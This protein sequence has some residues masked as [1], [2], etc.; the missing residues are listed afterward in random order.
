MRLF[1]DTS[2]AVAGAPGIAAAR[3]PVLIEAAS[4]RARLDDIRCGASPSSTRVRLEGSPSLGTI[5]IADIDLERLDDF[6]RS[7]VLKPAQIV[8]TK[9]LTV[10][11]SARVDLGG[12]EWQSV[13]FT[14]NEIADGTVTTV[15]TRDLARATV[16]SLISNIDLKADALGLGLGLNA[17]ALTAPVQPAL[18][19]AAAPADDV[20]NA[21]SDV[22][23]LHLGEA[24]LRVNGARCHGVALVG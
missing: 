21:L 7:L 14:G 16:A 6:T 10:T 9:L 17:G 1:L 13:T 19:A 3:L 18:A 11:G 5:A 24:D 2:V 23:G 4:A 22:V 8:T 15:Q 20:I 12:D